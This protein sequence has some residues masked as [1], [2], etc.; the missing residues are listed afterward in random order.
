[1]QSRFPRGGYRRGGTAAPYSVFEGFSDVFHD[2]EKWM[3]RTIDLK[4][5]GHLFAPNRVEF[6]NGRTFWDGALSDSAALR[7]A[8]PSA[9]LTSLIWNTR[10]ERQ[11]FQFGPNDD[12]R[13]TSMIAHDPNAQISVISGAWA[14]PLSESDLPFEE[15]LRKAARLHRIETDHL[16]ILT[17]AQTKAQVKIW[18][19]AEFVVS[20]FRYLQTIIEDMNL[21]LTQELTEPPQ[22]VELENVGQFIQHLKNR[23]IDSSLIGNLHPDI[24]SSNASETPQNPDLAR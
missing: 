2:F 7:D 10:K 18:T 8:N 5:H 6:F 15:I 19:L 23:G 22:L 16:A 1:M 3:K 13:I 20:P 4:L 9:F 14:V 21:N 24:A 11:C 12:Q 17:A